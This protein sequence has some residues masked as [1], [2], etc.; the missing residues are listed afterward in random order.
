MPKISLIFKNSVLADY[1]LPVGCS[2][3]IGRKT[4]NDVVIENLAVSGHHAKIDSVGD[5]FIFIDLKSKNGS[6]VNKELVTSHWLHDGD[7]INIGKHSL[8]FSYFESEKQ[9][10]DEPS[11]MDKTMVIDTNEY[12]AMIER[13]EPEP[14]ADTEPVAAV[15]AETKNKT[16]PVAAVPAETKNKTEPVA[17][18]PAETK[19]KQVRGYITYIIGGEG[20]LAL[21]KKLTKIGKDPS[22]D[23]VV[24][25]WAVGKTAAT[26]SRTRNGYFFSCDEGLSKPKINDSK[27]PK[28]PY[29]LVDS[30]IIAIGS[31]KLQF[32]SKK[33]KKNA[34]D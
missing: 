11:E 33:P 18:V 25:G 31:M 14:V 15:P 28:K 20:T 9:P 7:T 13:S 21:K 5:G 17:A 2:L 23:I 32:I 10:K 30:D 12:R 34:A 29:K 26:I 19:K 16:G 4:D 3:K 1:H 22:S 8:A 6:F 24:K 27:A